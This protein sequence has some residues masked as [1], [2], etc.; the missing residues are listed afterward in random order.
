MCVCLWVGG[1]CLEHSVGG[2]FSFFHS[3]YDVSEL[4]VFNKGWSPQRVSGVFHDEGSHH[5]HHACVLQN[6]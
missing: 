2:H 1:V 6:M 3:D 5:T 4:E